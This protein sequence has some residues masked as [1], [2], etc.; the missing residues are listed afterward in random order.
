MSGDETATLPTESSVSSSVPLWR[1]RTF[2]VLW[3]GQLVSTLGSQTMLVATPLLVL[4]LTGSP[5]QAG[6][7]AALESVP[8]LLFG[9]LAGALMDRR[10]RKIVMLACDTVRFL[11]V[12]SVP[13]AYALGHLSMPQLYV[14]ALAMGTCYVFFNIA[15]AASLPRVV[16]SAQLVQA[17]A[18]NETGGWLAT[19]VG[20][21]L[22]GFIVNLGQTTISGAVLAYLVNGVSYLASVISLGFVRIPIQADR[23]PLSMRALGREIAEGLHFVWAHRGVRLLALLAMVQNLLGAPATLAIIVLAR[24]DLQASPATIGLM[25]SALSVGGLLGS[26]V[27]PW[28]A[29]RLP[30]GQIIIGSMGIQALAV[31]LVAIAG[32]PIMVIAGGV[33]ITLVAPAYETMQTAY[34]LSATPDEL[35]GRINSVFR[36]LVFGTEPLTMAGTG[37]LLALVGPRA[38][39]WGIGSAVGLATIVAAMNGIVQIRL[40]VPRD[41]GREA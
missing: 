18:V 37:S 31:T 27:P 40:A 17:S 8:Y 12:G 22:G 16:P 28:I 29:P 13:L 36:L 5:A 33:I 25:F 14:V 24:G 41:S 39:L 32:S 20:P 11:V 2:L 3:S 30:A 10:N 15:E 1:N 19:I 38:V 23:I 26:L 35:Q 4:A 21:G 34:R 7:V 6:F 9:L